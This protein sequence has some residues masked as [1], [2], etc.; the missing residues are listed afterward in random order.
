MLNILH[1]M[2]LRL[3]ALG[4]HTPFMHIGM[5]HNYRNSSQAVQA[6]RD[7]GYEISLG[8]MPKSIGPL[9]FVFTGT[10]N[11]SKG[12]QEIFNELPCEYV[13]PHELKEVS[14]TGDLRKVYGTVLSRHHH[15]VRKT[16]GVYDPIE[17]DKHPE[18]YTSRFST[19]VSVI[20]A[21]ELAA[22]DTLWLGPF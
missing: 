13:E 17:Y 19:D 12:A 9:T 14:Q 3:L 20:P 7:A 8:L 16:D 6:V 1:G 2:G 5:A 10:G 18:R 15:L 11:V 22:H 4:H 21:P